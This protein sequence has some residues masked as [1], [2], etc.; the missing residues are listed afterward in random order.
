MRG[1]VTPVSVQVTLQHQAAVV[2]FIAVLA[3]IRDDGPGDSGAWVEHD[4]DVM[5]ESQVRAVDP[6]NT[7]VVCSKIK[8]SALNIHKIVFSCTVL[9]FVIFHRVATQSMSPPIEI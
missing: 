9:R 5:W 2:Q 8:K 4:E 6:C 7:H 1:V 3:S